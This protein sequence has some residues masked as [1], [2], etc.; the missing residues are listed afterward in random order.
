MSEGEQVTAE[1]FLASLQRMSSSLTRG[2]DIELDPGVC[3]WHAFKLLIHQ[4]QLR[5]MLAVPA[6]VCYMVPQLQGRRVG[7][8][9]LCAC[10]ALEHAAAGWSTKSHDFTCAERMRRGG[11]GLAVAWHDI[12]GL[13]GVKHRLRQ[14]VE[15]PLVHADAFQRLNIRAV[16]GVLLHGPPGASCSARI[17]CLQP[18]LRSCTHGFMYCHHARCS[19]AEYGTKGA[20]LRQCRVLNSPA[21]RASP[22]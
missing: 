13:Q 14:V 1:D 20:L 17:A 5:A 12:G 16:R 15:W 2:I 3:M 22:C 19:T 6:P 11:C 18:G 7:Y 10:L 21:G 4:L 8:C 9:Y